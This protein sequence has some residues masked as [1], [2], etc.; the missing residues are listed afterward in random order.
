MLC[1]ITS[2]PQHVFAFGVALQ[3]HQPE[4]DLEQGR[5]PPRCLSIT[6]ASPKALGVTQWSSRLLAR[7]LKSAMRP[8]PGRGV[9]TGCS[10][11][12]SRR[13]RSPPIPSWSGRSPT[14]SA[15]TW[16]RRRTRSCSAWM[17]SPRSRRWTG[18]R[19]CC[20][21]SPGGPSD[22]PTPT[23]PRHDH[24]FAALEVGRDRQG[25]RHLPT[26][27]SASRVPALPQAGSPR[28]PRARAAPGD[29]QLRRPQTG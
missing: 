7:R 19:R 8:G 20:R 10:R 12:G 5:V 2:N 13:S 25:H 24:L 29:A 18:P 11:G 15:C 28:L 6:T 17:R 9:T 3:G 26:P 4:V 21:C 14:W 16:F 27:A 22:A 23:A 1:T